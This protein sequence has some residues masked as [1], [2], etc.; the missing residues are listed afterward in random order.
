MLKLRMIALT[1]IMVLGVAGQAQAQEEY[2]KR[3]GLFLGVGVGIAEANFDL[4]TG[5]D[6]ADMGAIVDLRAGWAFY[7]RWAVTVGLAPAAFVYKYKAGFGPFSKEGERALTFVMYDVSGWYFQP[8]YKDIWK[9]FVR[10]GLGATKA[11]DEV[12]GEESSSESSAGVILAAGLEGFFSKNFAFFAELY[13]RSYGVTFQGMDDTEI[14]LVGLTLGLN[15][16]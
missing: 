16:R 15:Y 9:L 2:N 10:L 5:N 3:T 12:D 6:E 7:D 11:T 13:G 14:W 4:E 1:L 8:I